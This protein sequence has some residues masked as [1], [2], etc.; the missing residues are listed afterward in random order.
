MCVIIQLGGESPSWAS[1][2]WSA[3]CNVVLMITSLHPWEGLAAD[4]VPYKVYLHV[5]MH[6][7]S[8]TSVN[9]K[10]NE[11]AHNH[12]SVSHFCSCVN[13]WTLMTVAAAAPLSVI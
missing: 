7:R 4:M 10:P 9:M 3:A 12:H 13:L 5:C 2:V 8:Q 1:D 11:H 6:T